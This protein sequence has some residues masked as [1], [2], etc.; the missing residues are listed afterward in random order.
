MDNNDN[1]TH[2]EISSPIK[3]LDLSQDVSGLFESNRKDAVM[4][5]YFFRALYGFIAGKISAGYLFNQ[6]V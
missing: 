6:P 2:H 5:R 3:A 4:R 1:V